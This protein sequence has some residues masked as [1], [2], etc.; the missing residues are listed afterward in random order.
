METFGEL[1]SMAVLDQVNVT[2]ECK[3]QAI[4]A[5]ELLGSIIEV[6]NYKYCTSTI[7]KA[8]CCIYLWFHAMVSVPLIATSVLTIHSGHI[9]ALLYNFQATL[10]LSSYLSCIINSFYSLLHGWARYK[11][12]QLSMVKSL[13]KNMLIDMSYNSVKADGWCGGIRQSIIHC[14]IVVFLNYI[15]IWHARVFQFEALDQV[16]PQ[17][18][19]IAIWAFSHHRY[20]LW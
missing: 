12:N 14:F 17:Q 20:Q 15:L 2:D 19:W 13:E 6:F 5:L 11:S 9:I 8:A 16:A 4:F 7:Q 1:M 3:S 10:L 18:C